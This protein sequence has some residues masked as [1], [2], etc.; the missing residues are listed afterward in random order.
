MNYGGRGELARA[1]ASLAHAALAGE[2]DPARPTER[3]FARFLPHHPLP[4][5]ALPW[6]TGGERRVSN[7][8]PWHTAYS[9]P[10]SCG[11][12]STGGT[13]GR[14]SPP[15]AAGPAAS[16]PYPSH[17]RPRRTRTP[18]LRMSRPRRTERGPDLAT[19]PTGRVRG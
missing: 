19:L 1:G 6:R 8:R 5:V 13:C 14:R 16:A 10:T 4:D 3:D 2:L 12:M 15:T 9:E 18:T 17:V 11:P 7:F